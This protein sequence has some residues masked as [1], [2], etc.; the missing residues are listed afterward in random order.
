MSR[1]TNGAVNIDQG[2]KSAGISASCRQSVFDCTA[3]TQ[4]AAHRRASAGVTQ[5]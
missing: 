3:V 4:S 1:W 2:E 5:T